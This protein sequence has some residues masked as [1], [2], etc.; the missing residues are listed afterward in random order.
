MHRG[1]G[2]YFRKNYETKVWGTGMSSVVRVQLEKLLT[3]LRCDLLQ[4]GEIE[5]ADLALIGVA[6]AAVLRGSVGSQVAL[7]ED[8]FKVADAQLRAFQRLQ[9][10][11]HM[12]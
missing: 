10:L 1:S 12:A 11:C 8:I 3:Q 7:A 5:F 2:E 9:K 6:E 4:A